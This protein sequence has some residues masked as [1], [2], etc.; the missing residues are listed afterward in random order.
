MNQILIG[1]TLFFMLL[2]CGRQEK[3]VDEKAPETSLGRLETTQERKEASSAVFHKPLVARELDSVGV[4]TSIYNQS[5]TISPRSINQYKD[6]KKEGLW[7][8]LDKNGTLLSEGYYKNG[9]ANGWMKWYHNGDLAAEG[10]MIDG[11]RNGPWKICYVDDLLVCIDAYFEQERREGIW[12]IY[13]ENGKLMQVETW[14]DDK[15]I[16]KECW[17]ENGAVILCK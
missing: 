3:A 14:N 8:E 12:K 6:G 11:K 10:N 15:S 16:A 4:D 13:R 17:D 5:N 9:K 7:K 1:S 2:G